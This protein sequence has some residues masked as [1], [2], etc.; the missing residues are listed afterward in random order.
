MRSS[1]VAVVALMLAVPAF[2]QAAKPE[3]APANAPAPK[4]TAPPADAPMDQF[5]PPQAKAPSEG[6]TEAQK[7]ADAVKAGQTMLATTQKAYAKSGDLSQ[8]VSMDM[9][10]PQGKVTQKMK[11]AFSKGN[12]MHMSAQGID[13]FV[14]NGTAF[15]VPEQPADKYVE[16]AKSGSTIQTLEKALP[17]FAMPTPTL[18]YREAAE[19]AD[20]VAPF[21]MGALQ[22][23]RILGSRTEGGVKQ[24]L[25]GADNGEA[26]VSID[27]A[28]D[29]I[30][31]FT[32]LFTPEGLPPAIKMSFDI[33]MK[34]TMA[35][36]KPIAFDP[37][38]RKK[39]ASV[40][41]LMDGGD[42]DEAAAPEPKVKVG[43]AAPVS[44][45]PLLDGTK[46]NLADHKGK[47]VILD[48]WATWCGPC[49]KGLPLLQE[50][51]T[52]VAGNPKVV[53]Y[54]VNSWEIPGK[55][56]PSDEDVAGALK[57]AKEFWEKQ[58]FTMPCLFDAKSELIAR[59]GFNGI[60][61]TVIIGPDGS[62]VASH[63]GFAPNM[64]ELLEADVAKALGGSAKPAESTKNAVPA[65]GQ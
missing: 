2:G 26:L 31:T 32:V 46:V 62:L 12:D 60:P 65:A 38:S 58:K 63:M 52:S 35:L 21:G 1:F 54:A 8:E 56:D 50:Y 5:M 55:S 22:N 20:L 44:T 25:L 64:K 34:D 11:M 42:G 36:E 9:A 28:T 33:T 7:S 53:V 43:D 14:I 37:G 16:Q 47:V 45:L 29:M 27:P 15:V 59:Y 51:A 61:A 3:S 17:G 49:R 4:Q 41:E 40:M 48:F 57:K 13:I 6:W 19:G 23:P 18:A 24:V 39:V 30:R 10:A